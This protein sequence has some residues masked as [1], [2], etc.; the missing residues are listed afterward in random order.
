MRPLVR[1]TPHVAGDAPTPGAEPVPFEPGQAVERAGG[2]RAAPNGVD[3]QVVQRQIPTAPLAKRAGTLGSTLT[4]PNLIEIPYGDDSTISL[5]ASGLNIAGVMTPV[6]AA[7]APSVETALRA[8]I[9][10]PIASPTLDRLG[11]PGDQYLIVAD[12]M[13]RETPVV[14]MIGV[15]AERLSAAGVSD[16]QIQVLIATGTHRPM[17]DAEIGERFGD[18]LTS[19]FQIHNHDYQ[20][21]TLTDLGLTGNGTP[22]SVN[23][24]VLDADVVIGM[25]SI[26]PHHI[27][28][29]SGGSK[30]I[31]PGVSGELTTAS[32]HMFSA[33]SDTQILGVVESPV[34]R[35]MEEVAARAGLTT[36]LNTTLNA[37]GEMVDAFFGDPKAAFRAGAKASGRI[38]GLGSPS[39][40][41]IVIAGSHP[42]DIEFWQAHKSLFPAARIVRPGGT[43]IVVAPCPEGVAMTHDDVLNYAD[44]TYS[45][46]RDL[47]DAGAVA[48]P[49]GASNAVAW[50]RIREFADISLVSGGISAD[51]CRALGFQPFDSLDSALGD[52]RLRLGKDASVAVMTHAPDTLPIPVN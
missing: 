11:E 37:R 12:D 51:D 6:D 24:R 46:I 3:D 30:I 41:D 34:R 33:V 36:I 10:K 42:C 19:R 50:S 1:I 43:I 40:V 18:E 23:Q 52:A 8:A 26:V 7:G 22:I 14:A 2:R 39:N 49:V 20:T 29:Y 17:T 28:G 31:Q 35:E 38:Y 25:S 9:G 4:D 5:D 48:D 32:T 27:P 15:V 21:S 47:V 13:T 16:C 44:Q 45:R